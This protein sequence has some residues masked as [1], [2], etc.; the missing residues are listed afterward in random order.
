MSP[1]LDWTLIG[2]LTLLATGG[3]CANL[4]GMPGNWVIV[5]IGVGCWWL[6][7]ESNRGHVGSAALV[8]MIAAASLG[9]LLE[10]AASALGA[11]RVGGSKRGA[12][13]ALLGS[14]AGAISGLFVGAVIPIPVVGS[15]LGSLLLG[16]SGA[17]LG[18]VLG[19]RWVGRDWDASFQVGGAAFWGRLLG[20]I[21]KG[22]CGTVAAGIFIAAIWRA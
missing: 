21:G 14:I 19:E 8:G 16:A 2:I 1:W 12:A 20:T 18:A 15:L 22:V 5:A 17:F 11:S 9:E 4:L 10:F 7:P 13:L 3:W 6:V